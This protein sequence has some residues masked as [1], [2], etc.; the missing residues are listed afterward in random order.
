MDPCILHSSPVVLM[1]IFL[2]QHR[3][4]FCSHPCSDSTRNSTLAVLS[5]CLTAILYSRI[6]NPLGTLL[7][8][9][10]R[11]HVTSVVGIWT[12][13]NNFEMDPCLCSSSQSI[14][15]LYLQVQ[16]L[17]IQ[18]RSDICSG[19]CSDIHVTIYLSLSP[20]CQLC[21]ESALVSIALI[22]SSSIL[23][24]WTR[25]F[26]PCSDLCPCPCYKCRTDPNR[27]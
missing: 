3:L 10:T 5:I 24:I 18:L 15:F 22:N 12:V 6:P 2:L 16:T 7:G 20:S 1:W 11:I 26:G 17:A 4:D 14:H 23:Q 13:H 9:P 19:I 27:W 8:T 21:L 25:T